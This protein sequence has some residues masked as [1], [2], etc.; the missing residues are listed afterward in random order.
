MNATS[1]RKALR[2]GQQTAELFT[3]A[4]R[5]VAHRVARAAQAKNPPSARDQREFQLMGAEKFAAFGEAWQA[6]AL[7]ML[8][9]Q[10]QLA[11]SMWQGG[12]VSAWPSWAMRSFS[13]SNPW[14]ATWQS[15][16]LDVLNQG[17]APVRRRARANARRLGRQ[18]SR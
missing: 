4:P 14:T 15:T 3:A 13:A 10:A 7:Q 12:W 5:V 1:R 16:A 17:I 2:L 9:A 6:M 18:R 8:K 11:A